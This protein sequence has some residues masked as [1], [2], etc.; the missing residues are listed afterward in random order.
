MKAYKCSICGCNNISVGT[1]KHTNEKKLFFICKSCCKNHEPINYNI[2]VQIVPVS[3]ETLS[4]II[5]TKKY[6]Y[7]MHY[8]RTGGIYIAFY[9]TGGSGKIEYYSKVKKV[10][11]NVKTEDLPYN[12]G[13]LKNPKEDSLY[14]IYFF[15]KLKKLKKPIQRGN[16]GAIQNIRNTTLKKLKKAIY[17]DQL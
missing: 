1:I 8:R 13:K 3:E 7:P 14:K 11:I 16:S 15:D 9:N 4:N 10:M 5:K 12:I 6:F 2:E 17:L